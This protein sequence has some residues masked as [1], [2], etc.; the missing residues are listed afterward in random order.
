MLS[1]SGTLRPKLIF[2]ELSKTVLGFFV[3]QLGTK[4]AWG[5]RQELLENFPSRIGLI[6]FETIF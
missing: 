4:L 3:A 5:A 1:L 2:G 6:I